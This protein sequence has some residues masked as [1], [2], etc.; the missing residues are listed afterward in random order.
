MKYLIRTHRRRAP[1]QQPNYSVDVRHFNAD[2]LAQAFARY[3]QEAKRTENSQ[4]ELFALLEST[5]QH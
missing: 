2:E 3:T 1:G 5:K 4:V